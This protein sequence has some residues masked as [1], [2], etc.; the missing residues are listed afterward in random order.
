MKF[1]HALPSLALS[2]WRQSY[3]AD[4][5]RL[6]LH[7]SQGQEKGVGHETMSYISIQYANG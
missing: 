1:T 4:K 5:D 2:C 7:E 3:H 6:E